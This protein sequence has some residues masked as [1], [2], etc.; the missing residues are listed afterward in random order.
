M[1]KEENENLEKKEHKVIN[2]I[3]RITLALAFL[4]LVIFIYNTFFNNNHYV[5]LNDP[6]L[7]EII[8]GYKK[9]VSFD[10]VVNSKRIEKDKSSKNY[11]IVCYDGKEKYEIKVG[12]YIYKNLEVEEK[13]NVSGSIFYDKKGLRL[14]YDY[15]VRSLVDK[16]DN[17]VVDIPD[18]YK[19]PE[20]EK[21]PG[22]DYGDGVYR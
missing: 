1:K 20:P 13:I 5:D 4:F 18:G 2:F 17:G 16:D 22:V 15:Q 3:I 14:S 10:T 6:D 19:E 8:D 21:I 12:N 9:E 7:V 11:I